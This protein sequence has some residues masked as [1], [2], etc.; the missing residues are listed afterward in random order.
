VKTSANQGHYILEVPAARKSEIAALMAYRGAAFSL[1]ASNREKA[2]LFSDN[3]YAFC[4]LGDAPEL[5]AYKREIELS[6]ALDGVGTRKLP[7]GK[8]LWD[9]QKA[10]LDY[11]LARGGGI[12]GDQPGLGKTPTAIAFCNELEAARVLV[13]VPASVRIQWGERIREWST[14]PKCNVSIM[15]KVKDGIH[16]TANYQVISYDSARNPAIIRAIAKHQW[17][18][19]I[20]DEA[21]KMKNIEALTTRAVLG[22]TRGEYQHGN[23]KMPAIA[24][25]CT[26]HLALTGTLLLN[27]PSECY[28]LLRH[29]DWQAIDFASEEQFK[30][31]YN[32]Q[33]D[34]QTIEGKRFKLE[35]TSLENELQNRL[36]ANIMA[37]HEK[38]D[39]LPWMKVPRYAIVKCEENGAVKGALDVEGMLGLSIDEIQTTKDIE[40]LGHIAEARRLMGLALAPQIIDYAAD[41]LEGSEEKLVIFGW[42]IDVLSLFEEGLSRFGTVRFDSRKSANAKQQAVDDFI[43]LPHKRVFISNI[44]SGGTG[45]DG[46]QKVCS[47]CYLAEPDWVP[48]QNEQA[49]SRLDR[50]GQENLVN[51]E[52]F[53]APGSISEKILVRAL[54]KMN[55]IHRVLD[56]KEK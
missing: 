13:I 45:V 1:S 37:R 43:A 55:A 19:L 4:D 6:R 40:V 44:L 41:F 24:K 28:V 23:V 36:R 2:V 49:V 39:V 10:T 26:H 53:V 47:H 18:V 34:M 20:C 3:P 9:Y 7:P 38:R 25:Y 48:A 15:L 51:A 30:N 21:H 32:K 29:F 52:I 17:D 46:L 31:R 16:P 33:A 42:H 54:E 11:L 50:I 5:A 56:Q 35:S 22:N 14:I 12:D 27:R 8:A